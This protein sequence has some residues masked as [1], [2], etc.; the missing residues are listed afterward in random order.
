MIF[1]SK[2][3]KVNNIINKF[4]FAREDFNPEMILLQL[5]FTYSTCRLFTKKNKTGFQ[6]LRKSEDI[7]YIYQNEV[8]KN[9]FQRDMACGAYPEKQLPTKLWIITHSHLLL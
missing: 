8:D 6:K 5:G 4:L 9:C 7:R 3:I 1:C 2:C